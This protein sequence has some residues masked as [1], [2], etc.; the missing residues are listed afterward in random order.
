MKETGEEIIHFCRETLVNYKKSTL[1]DF[2]EVLLK[3]SPGEI[4]KTGLKKMCAANK[5]F[6]KR[7]NQ[8][9]STAG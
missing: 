4:P 5:Q 2:M 1:M 3:T 9:L 8:G 7:N 6:W